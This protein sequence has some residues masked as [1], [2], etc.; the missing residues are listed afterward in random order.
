MRVPQAE[1]SAVSRLHTFVCSVRQ[2]AAEFAKPLG[3][4]R[5][6]CIG[7][8]SHEERSRYYLDHHYHSSQASHPSY[9]ALLIFFS[10][11]SIAVY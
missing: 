3:F 9:L 4:R 2:I 1:K 11:N 6:L 5:V 10:S 8:H 7:R